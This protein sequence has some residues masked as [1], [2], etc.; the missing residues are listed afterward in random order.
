MLP[1]LL[2]SWNI[3]NFCLIVSYC[4]KRTFLFII[5]LWASL[6]LNWSGREWPW[7]PDCPVSTRV[8][9][10]RRVYA[11]TEQAL[12]PIRQD[13]LKPILLET[14]SVS[15]WGCGQW[16]KW[17]QNCSGPAPALSAG[18]WSHTVWPD[19]VPWVS[20][21]LPC[22][23]LLALFP[24]SPDIFG[25]QHNSLAMWAET[26]LFSWGRARHQITQR[27]G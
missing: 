4:L 18:W 3:K 1:V 7:T 27:C 14:S 6:A 12:H 24:V 10:H 16:R 8:L 20:L 22:P 17:R 19:T 11:K 21:C 23:H 26:G 13:V 5:Y 9:H 15:D 25:P 2:N